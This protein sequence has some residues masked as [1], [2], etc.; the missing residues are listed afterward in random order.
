MSSLIV[1]C[2][3]SF[4]IARGEGEKGRRGDGGGGGVDLQLWEAN[5]SYCAFISVHESQAAGNSFLPPVPDKHVSGQCLC[6]GFLRRRCV[7]YKVLE[8]LL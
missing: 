6:S 8:W 7:H 2:V 5:G 1:K 4:D 3:L